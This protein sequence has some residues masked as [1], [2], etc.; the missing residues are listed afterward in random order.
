MNG[1]I[2][3]AFE[4]ARSGRFPDVGK[5]ETALSREGYT[6]A[7]EHLAGAHIRKQ[8]AALIKKARPGG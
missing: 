7:R 1:A 3:R 8:L 2:E 6:G 5:L 4:M